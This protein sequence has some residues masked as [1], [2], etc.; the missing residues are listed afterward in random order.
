MPHIGIPGFVPWKHQLP[1][2]FFATA[3]L[4]AASTLDRMLDDVMISGSNSRRLGSAS[5]GSEGTIGR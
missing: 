5:R 2:Y 3:Q 1:N 4:K